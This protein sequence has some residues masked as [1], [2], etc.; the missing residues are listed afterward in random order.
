MPTF[1]WLL[2]WQRLKTC[3]MVSNVTEIPVSVGYQLQLIIVVVVTVVVCCCLESK[4]R[5]RDER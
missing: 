2:F 1:L 4:I 5:M 3:W